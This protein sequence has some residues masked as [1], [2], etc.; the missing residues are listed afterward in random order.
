VLNFLST[1]PDDMWFLNDS[2]DS[3]HKLPKLFILVTYIEF[4]GNLLVLH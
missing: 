2:L 1:A 4:Q 3:H